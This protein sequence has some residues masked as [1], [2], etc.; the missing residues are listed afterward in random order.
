MVSILPFQA[1]QN[2]FRLEEIT[3]NYYQQLEDER[4]KRIAAVQTLTISKHNLAKAKRKL[5]AEEQA[6]RSADSA[7]E[8]VE[9]QAEDQRRCLREANE[10]LNAAKEQIAALKKQLEETQKLKDQADKSKAE[11]EEAMDEAEQ[12]GYDL[13]VAETEETL[14]AEVSVVCR[15]YCA[16]TWDEALNRAGVKASSELRKAKNV[17][18]PSAIRASNPSSTQNEVTP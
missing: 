18:Y 11:A 15:I 6:C 16:Q 5:T 2:T 3:N 9:R 14:K 1:I 8:G 17:F 4:K 10:E 13:R 12:K 7:L